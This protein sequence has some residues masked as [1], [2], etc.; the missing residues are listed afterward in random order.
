MNRRNPV[1]SHSGCPRGIRPRFPAARRA[2]IVPCS[3]D[4]ERRSRGIL[5]ID[6]APLDILPA[7]Y[8]G[9]RRLQGL[10]S[11]EL[12]GSLR[13]AVAPEAP[14]RKRRGFAPGCD[15]TP[16]LASAMRWVLA[17][18]WRASGRVR[19]DRLLLY[20]GGSGLRILTFHETLGDDMK[21]LQ[22]IVELVEDL[23]LGDVAHA[24]R[25]AGRFARTWPAIPI[26][27]QS[28]C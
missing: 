3:W 7:T 11:D 6:S 14:R 25:L 8:R 15:L 4:G 13:C 2:I 16:P 1:P 19:R 23:C 27:R 10:M 12:A 26:A 28:N 18:L 17:E 21:R 9:Q 5:T 22:R 24:V 20:G